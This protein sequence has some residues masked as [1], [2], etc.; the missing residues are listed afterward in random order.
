MPL[1]EVTKPLTATIIV[2]CASKKEALN[3][4]EKIVVDIAD[5]EGNQIQSNEIISFEADVKVAEIK[6]KKL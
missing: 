3:W 1:F 2:E 6:I 5:K 4:A